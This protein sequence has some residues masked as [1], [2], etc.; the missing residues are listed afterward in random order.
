MS[1]STAYDNNNNGLYINTEPPYSHR[2]SPDDDYENLR[3]VAA[4][5]GTGPWS[6]YNRRVSIVMPHTLAY[7]KS[8]SMTHVTRSR[9]R[10]QTRYATCVPLKV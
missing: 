5:S 1:R 8:N 3:A 9:I 2:R 10:P 7:L 6:P 4:S